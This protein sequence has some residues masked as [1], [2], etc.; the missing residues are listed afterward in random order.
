MDEFIHVWLKSIFGN[1]VDHDCFTVSGSCLVLG[2]ILVDVV[3]GW[4]CW[5]FWL[6]YFS[7]W[8]CHIFRRS[9]YASPQIIFQ[10]SDIV[11]ALTFYFFIYFHQGFHFASLGHGWS[12]F[13]RWMA[14]VWEPGSTDAGLSGASSWPWRWLL[15]PEEWRDSGRSIWCSLFVFLVNPLHYLPTSVESR[16]AWIVWIMIA[17]QKIWVTTFSEDSEIMTANLTVSEFPVIPRDLHFSMLFQPL[18][19]FIETI[20]ILHECLLCV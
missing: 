6:F 3:S 5:S 13:E 20:S 14:W 7:I 19:K 12:R 10:I 2:W 4:R 15:R 8:Y 16:P 17:N 18:Y 9:L 11:E 1:D